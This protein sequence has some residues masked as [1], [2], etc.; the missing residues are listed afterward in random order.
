[1]AYN[2]PYWYRAHNGLRT[3]AQAVQVRDYYNKTNLPPY[4]NSTTPVMSAGSKGGRAVRDG[5]T[6]QDNP[7]IRLTTMAPNLSIITL[8]S[9]VE[10][11]IPESSPEPISA[12]ATEQ[13]APDISIISVD[14]DTVDVPTPQATAANVVVEENE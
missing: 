5:K 12:H 2:D 6:G 14:E 9:E 1:M 8:D 4:D 7:T 10:A 3:L 13:Q 11:N